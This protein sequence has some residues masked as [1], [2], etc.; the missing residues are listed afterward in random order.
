MCHAI[1]SSA[2]LLRRN[3]NPSGLLAIWHILGQLTH[4]D[5]YTIADLMH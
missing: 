3:M 1:P 5:L 4:P 2:L